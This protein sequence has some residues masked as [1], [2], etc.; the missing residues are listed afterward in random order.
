MSLSYRGDVRLGLAEDPHK[1][2]RIVAGS[3]AA[4]TALYAPLLPP[5]AQLL[6]PDSAAPPSQ[7]TTPQPPSLA[8]QHPHPLPHTVTPARQPAELAG[9]QAVGEVG[10]GGDGNVQGVM[11]QQDM[12]EACRLQ[13]L[14]NLPPALLQQVRCNFGRSM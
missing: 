3:G 11:W 12:G 1:I 2:S 9:L 8:P 5:A 13:L 4:M 14:A 10:E 6:N 7:L